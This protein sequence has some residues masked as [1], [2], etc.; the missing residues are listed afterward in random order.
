M[1]S[2]ICSILTLAVLAVGGTHVFAAPEKAPKKPAEERFAKLDANGDKK[3]SE[4]EFIG[5]KT[6]EAK[7]KAGKRFGK[8]DK[9]GDKS[10]SF[11]EFNV[12]PKK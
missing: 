5:K 11:E 4:E 8:L 1:K 7:D 12:T 10:L 3:L 6:G 9:D 2:M